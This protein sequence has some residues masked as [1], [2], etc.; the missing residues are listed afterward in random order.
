MLLS[1]LGVFH[2]VGVAV[3]DDDGGVDHDM[4]WD[5]GDMED[6]APSSPQQGP[7]PLPSPP[8]GDS[9]NEYKNGLKNR[10]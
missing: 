2:A 1:V 9:S 10:T 6:D 7:P 4:G 8:K 5:N 3:G